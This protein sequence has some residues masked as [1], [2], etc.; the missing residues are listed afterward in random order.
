MDFYEQES[1]RNIIRLK[2]ALL[3]FVENMAN[4]DYCKFIFVILNFDNFWDFCKSISSQ[5][6]S[7]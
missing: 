4:Q 6:D 3:K 1:Y 2:Y 7:N 5:L